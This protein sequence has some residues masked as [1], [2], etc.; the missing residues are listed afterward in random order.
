[1]L[2]DTGSSPNAKMTSLPHGSV[3]LSGDAPLAT[4]RDKAL[5]VT[6]PTMGEIMFS[7]SVGHALENFLVASGDTEGTHDGPPFMD[8]DLYKWLEAAV[9]ATS[10]TDDVPLRQHVADAA[11]AISSAQDDDG[12][13]HTKTIIAQKEGLSL[14]R[15]DERNDFETYNFGH[16]MTM[17]CVHHRATGEDVFLQLALRVADYLIEVARDEPHKLA[18]CNICPSHYMG[19]VEVYRTSGEHK[20][21]QLAGRLLDLHGGK[22]RDGGDDNQDVLSVRDQRNAVGHS[23]RANYLYAGMAD[24]VIETGDE[25]MA[26]ALQSIWNDLVS[27]KLYIT[28]G[29]GALYDGASP[30]AAQ[31]YYSV[32]KTHQAYGRPFQLPNTAGYNES[33]ASLGFVMW[34]W[35]MLTLTGESR[36]ADEIERV[37][38][39]AL[40]AM[41]GAEGSTYF[42]VNPLRQVKGLPYPLRRPGDPSDAAPPPSDDRGRQEYMKACFCCPPNIARVMAQLPY[43]VYSA[44]PSQVWVH[45]YAQ[46]SV[47]MTFGG[48]AVKVSQ[49]TTYPAS[50][51]VVLKVVASEAV[52]GQVR[53]RIPGWC[54]SVTV[55]VNGEP[56]DVEAGGIRQSGYLV[57][58]RV[59]HDDT[60]TLRLDLS[61]KLVVANA[62]LEET[63]GQAC[64]MRGPV[65]YCVES[66]DL[67]DGVGIESVSLRSSEPFVAEPGS[68]IFA[69][70]TL[71]STNAYQLAPQ[72]PIGQL[73]A[74]LNTAPPTQL[75]LTLVPY[76]MWANRGAGEM[77]VWLPIAIDS[78]LNKGEQR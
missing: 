58:E 9:V 40:P 59:W 24:Y 77:S 57:L 7:T 16:L 66:A 8:G 63:T 60:I 41:V 11:K 2:T 49:H 61:P 25:E 76:A 73:Y 68:G 4:L 35:R 53:L 64:V 17:A 5:T 67:P 62:F 78:A 30:D 12:Y 22:G 36:F 32:T 29:C 56:L 15:F 65:V 44:G 45:Q 69:G 3:T 72:V 39:N 75:D 33:C 28:G 46:G 18:N 38:Y 10:E 52:S 19:V 6:I 27:T 50:G 20:Y 43:Y 48:V 51:D 74:P 55:Q 54:D 37:L 42:Y 14:Q 47:D 23:V 21:L 31:D 34:A 13:L 71:V 26:A 70:H 1:M